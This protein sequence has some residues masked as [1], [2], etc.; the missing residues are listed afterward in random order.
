MDI[1]ERIKKLGSYFVS[2]NLSAE[3]GIIYILVSFPK[4]WAFSE[5]TECNFN[6]RV[7]KNEIPG[8]FYFFTDMEI[9]FEKLF[10]AI[11]YNIKFNE[12]AQIKVALLRDK[13]EELK[14]IFEKEDIST[15]KTLEF[16][17]KKKVKN[18]KKTKTEVCEKNEIDTIVKGT[19]L[20]NP[21]ISEED[22][23]NFNKTTELC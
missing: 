7:V 12:E 4:G 18:I 6:V 16:K 13:I 11:E 23:N 17:L 1:K 19:V 20:E 14:D 22:V 10:N 5:L 3:N 21:S 8:Q 15:L 9:G 2:M